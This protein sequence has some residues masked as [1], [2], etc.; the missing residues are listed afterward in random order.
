Q[1]VLIDSASGTSFG[2]NNTQSAYLM[3][4]KA[5]GALW[6]YGYNSSSEWIS[7][8]YEYPSEGAVYFDTSK[9]NMATRCKITG[10][11]V[12]AS[13]NV[14]G[15]GAEGISKNVQITLVSIS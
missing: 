2:A 12:G 3:L 1:S 7:Q 6:C 9:Q 11:G 5:S 14:A 15:S 8:A 10:S 13:I 4:H